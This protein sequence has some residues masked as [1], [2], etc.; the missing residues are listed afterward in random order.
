MPC[1]E[2]KP[3]PQKS[4]LSKDQN[5]LKESDKGSHKECSCKI[6]LKSSEQLLEKKIFK[7]FTIF[8]RENMPQPQNS[9]FFQDIK[10]S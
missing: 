5:V 4:C 6:W 10:I 3:H 1:R 2:N 9:C 8:Q 7:D